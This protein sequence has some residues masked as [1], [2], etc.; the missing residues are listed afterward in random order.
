[1]KLLISALEPSANL[2]LKNLLNGDN[3]FEIYGIFDESFGTPVVSPKMFSVMGITD[4]LSKIFLARKIIKTVVDN[5]SSCDKVLLIDAPAFNIPLA[6]AIKKKYPDKKIVYYILPKVWAW[7]KGRVVTVES[8]TDIQAYIFPFEKKYWNSGVYVG[9]PL[10][11]EIGL[12]KEYPCNIVETIAFLP[13]SRRSEIKKL[14]PIFK[15][16]ANKLKGRKILAIPN[17]FTQEEID[18]LY[19]DISEFEV[20]YD[21]KKALLNSDRAVVCSG[22]ATLE[23]AIIGVPFVLVYKAKKIDYFIGRLFVKL[24]HVGLANI[25]F[26][27][28]ELDEFHSELLQ[29]FVTSDNII[30]EIN[31]VDPVE[32]LK[33]SKKL[34]VILSEKEEELK[35]LLNS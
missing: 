2:H 22:T 4:V 11:N 23:A 6:K 5:C 27:Y 34:R 14:M 30:K 24:K 12:K 35:T 33:K 20:Y 9:N 1:M 31:K 28:E 13:G 15:D 10:M 32:F 8:V 3:S 21:A 29:E 18:E 25:I 19:G 16:C 26:D 17:I 7:K